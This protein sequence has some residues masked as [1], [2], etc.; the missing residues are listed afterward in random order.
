MSEFP[1]PPHLPTASDTPRH[2][3]FA[4]PLMVVLAVIA[5]GGIVTTALFASG[6][7][8]TASD[9]ATIQTPTTEATSPSTGPPTLTESASS[10]A[11]TT[12]TI[13]PY[14]DTDA[15]AAAL[16]TALPQSD[17]DEIKSLG[18]AAAD[19]TFAENWDV[20]ANQY[21]AVGDKY[22][23]MY[24]R[25]IDERMPGRGT[26]LA[27]A[28]ATSLSTCSQVNYDNADGYAGPGAFDGN[29]GIDQC[30]RLMNTAFEV[31]SSVI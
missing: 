9:P 17:F 21:R 2:N 29:P 11:T 14:Y 20:A 15:Y 16:H 4:G 25:A 6:F 3:R 28:I 30:N 18:T 13:D 12:T 7:I 27:E 26:A 22:Y 23:E 5:I 8:D 24:L 31:W 10:P 1:P 19:A